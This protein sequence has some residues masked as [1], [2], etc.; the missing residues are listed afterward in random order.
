MSMMS[1]KNSSIT[2]R[3]ASTAVQQ[4]ALLQP[5]TC[6]VEIMM[7]F[8]RDLTTSIAERLPQQEQ[9]TMPADKEKLNGTV[10]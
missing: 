3:W 8:K 9:P 1:L 6:L 4:T 7:T 2:K 10:Y 5:T